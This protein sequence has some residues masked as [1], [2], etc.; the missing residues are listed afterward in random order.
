MNRLVRQA[1]RPVAPQTGVTTHRLKRP[2]TP[3]EHSGLTD[4]KKRS[5]LP[6]VETRADT[7]RTGQEACPTAPR[8]A[9]L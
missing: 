6:R 2:V 7:P 9:G 3:G 1:S 8:G 5:S 4:H